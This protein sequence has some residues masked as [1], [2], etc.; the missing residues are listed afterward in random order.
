MIGHTLAHYRILAKLGEGGMGEVYRARDTKLDRDVAIKVLPRELSQ[1]PE[2]RK[3]FEREA[4]AVA[5]LRHPNIVMIHSVEE[6]DGTHFIT[7]ELVE[8]DTLSNVLPGDGFPLNR[9]FD[10]AIA[11]ADALSAAHAK[12]IAHR[13]LKPANIMIDSDGRI[14]V[15]DFGLA[16]LLERDVETDRT[17]AADSETGE[18]RIL[19]TVAYMSPEQ[20]EGQPIDHR[21]DVFSLGIILYEMATGQRPFKGKTNISTISSILKDTPRSVSDVRQSLPRHLGRIVNHC[22][23]KEPDRRY[24]SVLDVRNELEALKGEISTGEIEAPVV[25]TS[26]RARPKRVWW[27][28]GLGLVAVAVAVAMVLIRPGNRESTAPTSTVATQTE[29]EAETDR[30]I[31]VLPFANLSGDPDNEYFSDGLAEEVLNLLSRVPGLRVAARTSSFHFKGQTGNVSEIGRE[32]NVATILE[33]GVRRAGN[34][35]RVT[36]Q[37]VKAADGFDMWSD[38]Y[39][40]ELDDVFEIQEDIATQVVE[41]L[42]IK[43]LG[44]DAAR[45]AKRPTDNLEAY[46]AY[47][48]GQQRMARRR[49]DSLEEAGRYYQRAV[50]LDPGFAQAYAQMAVTYLLLAE[51]GTVREEEAR[52]LAEPLIQRALEI[53]DQLGEAYAARGLLEWNRPNIEA[54]E[55]AYRRAIELNPNHALAYM[56]YALLMRGRDRDKAWQ[57]LRK[58][59]ELDPLAPVANTNMGSWLLTEGKP[60]EA[61]AQFRRVIEI[62]PGFVS[63]Y[64][65]MAWVYEDAL[66]EPVKALEWRRKCVDLDPGSLQQRVQLGWTYYNAGRTED[67]LETFRETIS[68]DP[69]FAPA[70]GAMSNVYRQR[71]RLDEAVRWGRKA[72]DRDRE[73]FWFLLGMVDLYLDLGDLL[74]ATEWMERLE[75]THPDNALTKIARA[76]L[77]EFQ[78]DLQEAE[79]LTREGAESVP[80]WLRA[81]LAFFDLLGG[82]YDDAR[83]RYESSP[84]LEGDDPVVNGTNLY[85]A[86]DICYTLGAPEDGPRRKLL[87]RKSEAYLL[88]R[89]PTA[90]RNRYP[91]QMAEIRILQGRTDEALDLVEQLVQDGFKQGWW[92]RVDPAVRSLLDNPRWQTIVAGIRDDIARMRQKLAADGLASG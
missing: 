33:G 84:L 29:A 80:E 67:A 3:R 38:T 68:I 57:L 55:N 71:G 85:D 92:Q 32:L 9:F 25:R 88:S 17:V 79:T 73:N 12:G 16:K 64:A 83:S 34:R 51:Y 48:L 70:Y 23:A 13:D 43:L 15:L 4:K 54:A 6:V 8:G 66:D 76:E 75:K 42:K 77:A 14:R 45:I 20:A 58:S 91:T 53:D 44:K 7:M 65:G 5:A 37:L 1:D 39:D 46:D 24:Q 89:S 52:T 22:L 69:G 49:S 26:R 21:S 87:L 35:V 11:L 10:Y 41:A 2:R 56:W 63:G 30:S 19:G 86:I 82:R 62:D 36:A 60:E 31:A 28:G 81:R 90:R 27:F 74:K 78:G 61:E 40:R 72:V 59:L 50:D 47:L 18:G